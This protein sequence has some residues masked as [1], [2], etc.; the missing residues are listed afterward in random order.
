MSPTRMV[1]VFVEEADRRLRRGSG[2]A[3]TWSLTTRTYPFLFL[4][5]VEASVE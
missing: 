1:R 2:E 3:L 5:A 4:L